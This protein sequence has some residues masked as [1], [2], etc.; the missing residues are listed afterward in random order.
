MFVAGPVK[1][2]SPGLVLLR[3]L[4]SCFTAQAVPPCEAGTY[5]WQSNVWSVPQPNVWAFACV[6]EGAPLAQNAM[7]KISHEVR[8]ITGLWTT[9]EPNVAVKM[10]NRI[11]KIY[12]A[13]HFG[14][15]TKLFKENIN[16]FLA[17][18]YRH[19]IKTTKTR[20][21]TVGKRSLSKRKS[22]D[23]RESESS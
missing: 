8:A 7:C 1:P 9:S 5:K 6:Q 21:L 22:I 4:S 18:Y 11:N 14:E 20:L 17:I 12:C 23:W 19:R 16:I 15:D 3:T 10:Q 13:Q 2:V